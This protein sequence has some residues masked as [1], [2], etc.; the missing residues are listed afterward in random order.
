MSSQPANH[1]AKQAPRKHANP[2]LD[3]SHPK[4]HNSILITN[5]HL[6]KI[7][8]LL[9]LFIMPLSARDFHVAATG[10]DAADGSAAKPLR[11]IQAA[12]D[13]AQSGD[14]VTVHE[15]TYREWVNPPRGGT[16]DA[17]R[18]TYQAAPGA[19]VVITGSE[20]VSGW[21]KVEG[22]VWKVVIPNT[23]FGDFNPYVEKVYGDWFA[24]RDRLYHRGSVYL[25]NHWLEEAASLEDVLASARK[26]PA[27]PVQGGKPKPAKVP[28]ERPQPL[29]Y[30]TVEGAN[31]TIWAQFPGV[32]PNH[33]KVEIN[34]RPTVFTPQKPNVDYLT[35]RG[36][37]LRN[38]GPNW[39]TPTT[40]QQ[41]LLTAY[42]CKGW[43]IEDNEISYSKCSGIALA[44]NSDEYDNK[45]GSTEGYVA[46]IDDALG[47]WGWTKD[48]IG[49]HIVRRNHIH[50][51]G[52]AGIVGSLGCAFSRIEGNEIHDINNQ[53]NWSG[54]ETAGI[55]FH[56]AIDVVIHGNHLYRCGKFGGIY[57]DWMA[58]GTH[59]TGNLLHDNIGHD[60]FT[61]VNHGPF[62]VANNIMLSKGA[63]R[64]NSQGG[65]FAHNLM[66]GGFMI[67]TDSR[68]TPYHKAH[69]TELAGRHDCA[70]GD[71]RWHNNLFGGQ[72]DLGV[73]DTASLPVAAD[74]NVFVGSAKP[75]RFDTHSLVQ[76]GFDPGARIEQA[77]DGWF[78]T[79]A[80]DK[81]WR[82]AVKRSLV[83]TELLG[84]ALI[85]DQPFERPDGSPL[86]VDTDY[87]GNKRN[88]A[89][90]APGPFESLES[91]PV[92]LKV[93]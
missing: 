42:W 60:L 33:A 66:L 9:V 48:K 78:L 90:P 2:A 15:G 20:P 77:K 34:V 46:T 73:F 86:T 70:I 10:D 8:A 31:T 87:F 30:A 93:W 56:G 85:P 11:T 53:W 27:V 1:S 91:G 54:C 63:Y 39:A 69:S 52:Q 89:N 7:A 61:E 21:R 47:R 82:D 22:D 18:I 49:G 23:L 65:A 28:T 55:K 25:E 71:M 5:L 76:A 16:D 24:S 12:A 13:L 44:K 4:I 43:I 37:D 80:T 50:H 67:K 29:W 81:T 92:R 38:A 68:R 3:T 19:K 57:L 83:T 32:D 62:L 6:P 88:P 75:S 51:C 17:H 45:R 41:G 64:S 35:V 84:K 14:S 40:G 72:S 74:G 79:L 58:Q 26:K 59:I 36:F